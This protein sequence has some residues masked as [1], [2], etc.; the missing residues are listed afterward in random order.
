MNLSGQDVHELRRRRQEKRRYNEKRKGENK[1][2]LLP[3]V[4]NLCPVHHLQVIVIDLANAIKS[5]WLS[6]IL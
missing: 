4:C 5:M 2:D 1:P 6:I 3:L